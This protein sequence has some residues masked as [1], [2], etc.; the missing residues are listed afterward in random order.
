MIEMQ[1]KEQFPRK[2]PA[3]VLVGF[4]GSGK[5]A[6]L[7]QLIEWC[8]ERGL[9]PGLIINEFPITAQ[10]GLHLALCS[11]GQHGHARVDASSWWVSIPDFPAR[12]I[13]IAW[14]STNGLR[15]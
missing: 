2:V 15:C 9:K 1:K 13:R 6:V 5:T 7:G 14:A 3:Y 8:V 4:L 11:A 12:S 10:G